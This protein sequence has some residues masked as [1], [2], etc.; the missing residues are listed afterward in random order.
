MGCNLDVHPPGMRET[1]EWCCKGSQ[2]SHWNNMHWKCPSPT[3][4]FF[5]LQCTWDFFDPAHHE[6][7]NY[8]SFLMH[9]D[10]PSP[11]PHEIGCRVRTMSTECSKGPMVLCIEILLRAEL[12]SK[13]IMGG[14]ICPSPVA[15]RTIVGCHFS[16]PVNLTD[17]LGT[18]K[19]DGLVGS[20]IK[21]HVGFFH[22]DY[23]AVWILHFLPNILNRLEEHCHLRQGSR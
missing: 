21:V 14:S 11:S 12:L 18:S 6:G 10:D 23:Q 22:V 19:V 16:A 2:Q 1:L 20:H 15:A 7:A 13:M 8:R 4:F 9:T 17:R 3:L 5:C